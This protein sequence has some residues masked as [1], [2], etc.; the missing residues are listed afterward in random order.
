MKSTSQAVATA[1]MAVAC[2]AIFLVTPSVASAEWETKNGK[3]K[4][5]EKRS[6]QTVKVGI[7]SRV[8]TCEMLETESTIQKSLPSQEEVNIGGHLNEKI[9]QAVKCIDKGWIFTNSSAEETEVEI[10]HKDNGVQLLNSFK[11]ALA[12]T[13]KEQ[14]GGPSCTITMPATSA[15]NDLGSFTAENSG[16]N[17]I[18]NEDTTGILIKGEENKE[19]KENGVNGEH[20]DGE[21]AATMEVEN[22]NQ[23]TGTAF[24]NAEKGGE[25]KSGSTG[26]TTGESALQCEESVYK[27]AAYGKNREFEATPTYGKCKVKGGGLENEPATVTVNSGCADTFDELEHLE[28]K[29]RHAEASI[30]INPGC[31]IAVKVLTCTVEINGGQKHGKVADKNIK[32]TAGE[33]ESE[34]TAEVT[35]LKYAHSGICVGLGSGEDGKYSGKFGGIKGVTI[36]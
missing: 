3:P 7:F 16:K 25:V 23:V 35:G 5:H 26:F 22:V 10:Q 15:N 14:G 18:I 27:W 32:E 21:M 1:A 30:T 8:I 28:G 34:L 19:C 17:V 11:S 13:V 36:E 31:K 29:P 20:S 33:L 4:S 6:T 24:Y 12:I 2:L 9:K